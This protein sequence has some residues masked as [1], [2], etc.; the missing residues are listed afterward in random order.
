MSIMDVHNL[1][2]KLHW[3][4]RFKRGFFRGSGCERILFAMGIQTS[5]F[6][7]RVVYNFISHSAVSFSRDKSQCFAIWRIENRSDNAATPRQP[8]NLLQLQMFHSKSR[9]HV[10]DRAGQEFFSLRR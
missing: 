4:D 1:T 9:F 2:S 8:P 5:L 10:Q 7:S 3:V 6:E